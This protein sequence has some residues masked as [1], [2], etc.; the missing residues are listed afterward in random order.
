[1]RQLLVL[2]SLFGAVL[3]CGTAT[4]TAPPA[5]VVPEPQPL[6]LV[7]AR[8]GE[9]TSAAAATVDVGRLA[10][11]PVEFGSGV[12]GETVM[13]GLRFAKPS[14]DAEVEFYQRCMPCTGKSGEGIF[15][16]GKSGVLRLNT[17]L[18]DTA[19]AQTWVDAHVDAGAAGAV[20]YGTEF[21]ALAALWMVSGFEPGPD[22]AAA[23]ED[24]AFISSINA[25]YWLAG[26]VTLVG[27][28]SCATQELRRLADLPG[29]DDDVR[30]A[31]MSEVL[32]ASGGAVQVSVLGTVEPSLLD[33]DTT[34]C[35]TADVGACLAVL[36]ALHQVALN[37]PVAD[38]VDAVLS[39]EHPSWR[40]A[41]FM[42]EFVS[43]F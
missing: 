28:N 18:L 35:T 29:L 14:A 33:V 32:V 20:T 31:A 9:A 15:A 37:P 1:M 24:D 6:D 13:P 12:R 42:A 25:V 38:D 43:N 17:V 26:N 3:G 2:P 16:D 36:D 30:H 39:G 10:V 7:V 11:V 21:Y 40:A 8:C 19:T 5:P 22:H 41:E 23:L 4:D 34:S 27:G